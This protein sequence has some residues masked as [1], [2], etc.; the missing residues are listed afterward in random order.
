MSQVGRGKSRGRWAA[1]A[2]AILP[3][4]LQGAPQAEARTLSRT[5]S[6]LFDRLAGSWTGIGAAGPTVASVERIACRVDYTPS[7]PAHLHMTLQCASP[8]YRVQVE[9]ELTRDGDH[10]DGT[11]QE[12]SFG[13]SGSL[14]GTVGADQLQAVVS[15]L[16]LSASLS[17]TMRG[18]VQAVTLQGLG[19][20][21][22]GASVRLRRSAA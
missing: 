22:A 13:V 10:I 6:T 1:L 18:G 11:L 20:L 12:Q 5:R 16:G 21:S 15:G 17:M 9:G 7:A 3:I 8:S 2:A 4:L 14:S 19:T